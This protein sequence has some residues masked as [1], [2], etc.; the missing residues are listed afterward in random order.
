MVSFVFF[1]WLLRGLQLKNYSSEA[2]KIGMC[3]N[4]RNSTRPV[5]TGRSGAVSPQFFV[6]PPTFFVPRK[7]FIYL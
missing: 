2:A 4:Q 6:T 3:L 7:R 1:A 5:A